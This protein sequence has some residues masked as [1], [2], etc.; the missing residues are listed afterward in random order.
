MADGLRLGYVVKRYPR[1]S[2]TFIV[3]EILAHERAGVPVHIFAVRRVNEPHFQSI[4]GEVRAPVS[5]ISDSVPKAEI[6][7]GT[8]QAGAAAIS[9][10]WAK[11]D[12]VA[13]ADVAD[14]QQGI[15]LAMAAREAGITHLHAH[16]ATIA[17]R[18]AQLAAH[19]ADIP[20]SFTGHAKDLFHA[21]VDSEALRSRMMDAQAVVTVSDF[22]R[23]WLSSQHGNAGSRAIRIYN[24]LRLKDFPYFS[25]FERPRKIIAVGRLVE[26]KGLDV[27][28]EAC[29]QLKEAGARFECEIIGDGPLNEHLRSMIARLGLDDRVTMRGALP[30]T[31]VSKAFISSAVCAV[32]CVIAADGD[33]DGL[34]T[35]V[36]EAMALGTPCVATDVTGLPEIVRDGKTGLIVRQGDP[37]ALAAALGTLLDDPDLRTKLSEGARDLIEA[38]FDVDSNA[39]EL[40]AIF[41]RCVGS[42]G[43][44]LRARA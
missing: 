11:L 43:V 34:P 2:E 36:V 39:A 25:P 10:F 37:K 29:A 16:F 30:R 9:D 35:V 17:T 40:R 14:V 42:R 22:N 23:R 8:L 24:G 28:I 44:P 5:Y 13:G 3:N 1:F 6:F 18:I 7:W 19:F 27:L 38:E 15:Q 21:D 4:V 41:S 31:E 12:G 32:P 33:R 26:K 20:Y